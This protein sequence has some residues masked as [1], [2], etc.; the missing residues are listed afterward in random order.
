MIQKVTKKLLLVVMA[1]VSLMSCQKKLNTVDDFAV[2]PQPNEII[3]GSGHFSLDAKTVFTVENGNEETDYIIAEWNRW[4]NKST[5]FTTEAVESATSNFIQ[6]VLDN[7]YQTKTEGAYSCAIKAN[8]IV[9]KS[10]S[11]VGLYYGVQTLRQLLPTALESQSLQTMDWNIPVGTINDAPRFSYR[12]LHLDVGRHFFPVSFLKKFIDLLAMHK[13]NVFHWHLTE[14]QGWRIEIK[15][16]PLLTE[17]GSKRKETIVGHGGRSNEFD[18][19][20]YGGYYTQEEIKEV[21]KYAQERFVTIIPEIELPGHSLGALSAYPHLGCTGGPYEAATRWGV[22]PDVYCA[23]NED[24]FAFLEGVMDEVI[25]LFP[26]KYIHIGGDECPKGEWKKCPKC[27]KRI[28]AEGLH[29]E[30]E[31]QSYFITRMEK[32]LESKGRSII[33]WDEILEGGLA[34]NATVMSWRGEKGGIEAAKQH[35]NVIMTPGH[36]CYLDHYQ[37]NPA[38][39]PLAIGGYTTTSDCYNYN[40][41]PDELSA[42][43][44][45]Y[46]LG[47]QGNIWTEYMP[48]SDHVEY[49]AYPRATALAEVGWTELENK[50]WD[51]FAKRLNRQ[52]KRFDEIGVN[53]F[54]KVI[55]PSPSVQKVEFIDEG[56]LEI[57][58]NAIGTKLYYT[59]D[60]SEPTAQSTEYTGAIK[61][62]QEGIIKAIAINEEGKK[63]NVLEVKAIKLEYIESDLKPGKSKGLSGTL[64][65]GK[66]K[67][68]AQ[69]L[70]QKGKAVKTQSVTLPALVPE[71]NYGLVLDGFI[72]VP[73]KGLYKLSLS[74]DDG[75]QLYFN[76][77]LLIDNDGP[78]GMKAKKANVALNAAT[79]PI[80]VV[81]F[82]GTGGHGLK[83]NVETPSGEKML[84]PAEWLTF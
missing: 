22:F 51:S 60:G 25:E 2:I 74:S 64:V 19:K 77:K 42:E 52:F 6:L 9:I 56:S 59:M 46:I 78:H 81:F 8:D 36:S 71:F 38:D 84:V 82:Q 39:E 40:P 72:T 76:N 11:T 34:P 7:N 30:H 68:C 57:N 43:E 20:E 5:G 54:N 83:L 49:M 28:K 31:L 37:N 55:M 47:V 33:G 23:G 21:V 48:N 18:G 27:Q 3:P 15:K 29:D 75:S 66:F 73:E 44:K 61:I 1:V 69:V 14:D 65:S 12:G 80:R 32:Y 16:Y 41:T 24:V 35:H 13:M 17:I 63:S 45:K 4:I 67:K 70:D 62:N 79:Y 26:S 50:D 53:Y 58:N 10:N